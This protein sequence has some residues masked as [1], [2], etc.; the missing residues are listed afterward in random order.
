MRCDLS[1]LT[2]RRSWLMS[3]MVLV[4]GTSTSMPDCR[5]GAV[6][7]KMMS[8]TRTT[9]TNGTMLI[10]ESDVC[11]ALPVCIVIFRSGR[12]D[13]RESLIKCFLD[14]RGDFHSEIVQTL[15]QVA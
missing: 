10:S 6:I 15:R 11:V 13:G 2:T 7:M 5:M 1:M 3:L 4:L 14:L 12:W 9:S 8:N